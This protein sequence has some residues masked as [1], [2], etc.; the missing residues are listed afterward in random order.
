VASKHDLKILDL[1]LDALISRCVAVHNGAFEKTN[2]EKQGTGGVRS[3]K[4]VGGNLMNPSSSR[5]RRDELAI[6]V[7]HLHRS[8]IHS[9]F[10]IGVLFPIAP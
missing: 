2:T 10:R 6:L 1:L 5:G 8:R 3:G 4:L 9:I 7:R